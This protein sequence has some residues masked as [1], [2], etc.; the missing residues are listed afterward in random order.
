MKTK[1]ITKVLDELTVLLVVHLKND[2]KA[3]YGREIDD[4][5]AKNILGKIGTIIMFAKDLGKEAVDKIF[6]E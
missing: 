4:Q 3:L 5:S 1:D 6:T 2:L